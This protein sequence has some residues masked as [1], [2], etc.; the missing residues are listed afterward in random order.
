MKETMYST[1]RN[2]KNDL[3]IQILTQLTL[4]N[5]IAMAFKTPTSAETGTQGN[6][7]S[8]SLKKQLSREFLTFTYLS[9]QFQDFRMSPHFSYGNKQL[10]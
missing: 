3:I 10:F 9:V 2:I 6:Q 8:I 1:L 7:A 4:H 5:Y